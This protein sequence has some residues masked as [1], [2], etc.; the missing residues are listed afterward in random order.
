MILTAPRA[1]FFPG[2]IT[3][4]VG[5]GLVPRSGGSQLRHPA[6]RWRRGG[7]RRRL[8]VVGVSWRATVPS[9]AALVWPAQPDADPGSVSGMPRRDGGGPFP[10]R[11]DES[12]AAPFPNARRSAALAPEVST[13]RNHTLLGECLGA[14]STLGAHGCEH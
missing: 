12:T 3:I 11:D 2:G 9:R 6:G 8:A 14:L 4:M 13:L 7:T 5:W 10:G 1:V